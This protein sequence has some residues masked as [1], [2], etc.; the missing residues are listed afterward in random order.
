M[1]GTMTFQVFTAKG[2]NSVSQPQYITV[3]NKLR[4]DYSLLHPSKGHRDR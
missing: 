3:V 4:V 1:F 2:L